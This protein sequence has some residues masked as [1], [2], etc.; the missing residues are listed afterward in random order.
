MLDI[1]CGLLG[2]RKQAGA[3]TATGRARDLTVAWLRWHYSGEIVED[4]AL[5][6]ILERARAAGHR[7]CLVQGYGHIVAEHAGPDG[8]KARG[9]FDAL[10]EWVG[11]HDFVFAG[12]P[13]RC[14]LVDLAAWSRAGEPIGGAP[15]PFEPGLDGHLIDLGT[16]LATA[17]PFE[18]F[19]DE[20]CDKAGRGVFVLNYE[21]YDDVAEPPPGFAAPVSTLYCVAAGLK[22]NRILA[23]HGIGAGTRVVFF[24][25]S[26]DALAFRRRLDAEWDGSDYP[27]YLRGLFERRDN[28]HYYLWPGATPEDMDWA[29]LER[30]WAA[31]LARWDGAEAFATHWR[32]FQA[33]GREYLACN[34]LEPDPLLARI[35]DAPGSAIWW[36]NAFCTIY[37]AAHHSLDEK[38][39]IYEG[40]IARLADRAPGIFLYGSDHSNSSVNAITARDYRDLYFA[41]GGDPLSA[42]AFH[43]QAIRF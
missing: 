8:G 31:E 1:I 42:R 21:S 6:R 2:D 18:A 32:R 7:Y 34:I 27:R 19:L 38:R 39:A 17:A 23:T 22:P 4:S 29:E 37:S 36:S 30:L 9:F 41:Q 11:R 5:A 43:R 28:T 14:L 12:V 15:V 33:I 20:M 25:Y 16:D 35:E 26:A 24:D 3:G 13:G 40:W 10:E